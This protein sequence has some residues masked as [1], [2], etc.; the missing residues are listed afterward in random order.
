[1]SSNFDSPSDLSQRERRRDERSRLEID[2]YFEGIGAD[3]VASSRDIGPGGLYLNTRAVLPEGAR[4][5]LRIPFGNRQFLVNA[6][7]VYSNPGRG[8]GVRFDQLSEE[9]RAALEQMGNAALV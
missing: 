5:A 6:T 9:A 8:V 1:M 7:V 3:G 4:L 2:I